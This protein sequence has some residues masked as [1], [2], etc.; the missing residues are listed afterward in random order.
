V[1]QNGNEKHGAQ[2]RVMD[3]FAPPQHA[4]RFDSG[5]ATLL[6]KRTAAMAAPVS[7]QPF[8]ENKVQTGSLVVV[9]AGVMAV[10]HVTV[11]ARGWIK[12]S[13]KVFCWG[14]DPV[15]E[16]WIAGLNENTKS[17]ESAKALGERVSQFLRVGLTVCAVHAGDISAW[18]EV[19]QMSRREGHRVVIVAGISADDCLFSDLGI[20][21]MHHGVQIYMATDFLARS[22]MPDVSAG[23][24]LRLAEDAGDPPRGACLPSLVETLAARYGAEHEAIL[25]EPARYSV[26][27]PWIRRCL[28][29]DLANASVTSQTRLYVPPKKPRPVDPEV[30][31]RLMGEGS[32]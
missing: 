20:D 25:H 8:A 23:L 29:G 24:L 19:L 13:D 10:N 28:I 12:H 11:E 15:T 6:A 4:A 21:P 3:P 31:R 30:L 17:L 7:A 14:V 16:R 1:T 2:T 18:H 26:C 32:G 9:N 5:G 22:L 27:N